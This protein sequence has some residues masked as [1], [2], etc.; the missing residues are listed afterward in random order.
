MK[1]NLS[2]VAR[3]NEAAGITRRKHLKLQRRYTGIELL[4]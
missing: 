1:T 3:F 2:P 4:Q